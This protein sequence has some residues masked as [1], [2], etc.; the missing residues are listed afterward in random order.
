MGTSP[1][2]S[3]IS[4]AGH[5]FHFSG[6]YIEHDASDWNLLC[7]PGMGPHLLDL[8]PRIFFHVDEREEARGFNHGRPGGL[9]QLRL[10]LIVLERHH[11]ADGYS[12]VRRNRPISSI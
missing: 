3:P 6:F 11:T 4:R 2:P 8:F 1:K 5:L 12:E 7:D 9:S 10:Q